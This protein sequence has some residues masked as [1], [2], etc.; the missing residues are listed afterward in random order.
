MC[1]VNILSTKE[2]LI[3]SSF[4]NFRTTFRKWANSTRNWDNFWDNGIKKAPRSILGT[5]DFTM[6]EMKRLELSTPRLRTWCSPS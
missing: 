5:L 1:N 2:R 4:Q 6:V 3:Y